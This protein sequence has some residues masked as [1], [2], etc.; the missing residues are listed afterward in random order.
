V[1]SSD[2][3]STGT[4]LSG[5]EE[6][7]DMRHMDLFSQASTKERTMRSDTVH[8]PRQSCFLAGL[9]GVKRKKSVVPYLVI[10]FAV[11]VMSVSPVGAQE[12]A[13]EPQASASQAGVPQLIRF[14]GTAQDVNG[15]GL[16][17]L[18]GVTFSIYAEESGGSPLWLETQN[19]Q[20]DKNGRY[21]ALL[22]ATKPGGLPVELFSS[23][24]SRWLSVRTE[25][26]PEQTR[27]LLVAVPYALKASDAETI[28]GL[29][30]S[31]FVLANP[32]QSAGGTTKTG[33][34]A[35]APAG[36]A[37]ANK[38]SNPL[39][40]AD[41][42]GKGVVDY[43]PMWD[44][45]S[46]II[47]SMIFQKGS[48]IGIGTTA[49]AATL[50]VNGKSDIR[51][52]LTLFPKGTDSPL[53]VSGTA[54]NVSST[55]LVTFV[56]TQ[57]FPGTGDGTITGIT[58][59]TG[60]GL[61]GG[62]T[63]GTLSLKVP[64]AGITNAMLADSKI[65]LN[66]NT[67]G[68]LTVPGAMTLGDTYTIGLIPCAT[69][70]VLQWSG[71][72]WACATISGSGTI[73]GVTAGTDLTGGGTSGNVTL[74]LNT[75]ATNALYAQLAANNTFTGQQ[76]INNKEIITTNSSFEVV[77]V[78]QA[79]GTGDAI[80]GNTNS[81]TGNGVVG[82]IT[83]TSGTGSG[84]LGTTS[85][86][87]GYG[88]QGQSA[89]VGVYGAS[90]GASTIGPGFGGLAGVWGDT[91]GSGLA[92][93]A[94][95]IGT[96]DNNPAGVFVNN[97]SDSETIFVDN[98]SESSSAF[99]L[100]AG[101]GSF[102]EACMIDVLGDLTCSGTVSGMVSAAGGAQK[103]SLHAVQSPENWFEDFGSG[104]LANGV[105]T[106][107][108]DPTFA[109]TVNTGMEYH[110]FLTP[111]G[112]SE[113]LYVSNETPQ[114]FEVHEQRGGHSN[115]AFDYR[116]TAKRS[117]YENKRLEDV[118]AQYKKLAAQQAQMRQRAKPATQKAPVTTPTAAPKLIS[119]EHK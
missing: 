62:G 108:L 67:A 15:N 74:N 3:S 35:S 57:K 49:P 92:N 93:Y 78:T 51:D 88:V 65:T 90:A 7:T 21:T 100:L 1:G 47:D 109:Q 75:T 94:G 23:G 60:S 99:V 48:E 53:T 69:S 44:T 80:H 16:T 82:N 111:K 116:I 89:N 112:D 71:S 86:K 8:E 103:V 106:I 5:Y 29:P 43:I 24:E 101:G 76:N 31:A 52:T 36:N 18:V 34:A 50:D 104:T 41:V 27:A 114:G 95:V 10:L 13:T 72:K 30:P 6:P 42:T 54:F 66:A 61:S 17:G 12:L 26:Q 64:A 98:A 105:A 113:G 115:V 96:A 38:S 118:T 59:A 45:T 33:G 9:K 97:S 58:T 85:S 81:T 119:A 20:A 91:G 117:G 77:D 56:S 4:H 37:D 87:S 84:V 55:G 70:Q 28:G 25:S 14:T 32:A 19:V 40:N 102:N 79:G 39:V 110:V 11:C 22:G 73:T 83:A 46:D 63:T 68:G 2:K 107:A